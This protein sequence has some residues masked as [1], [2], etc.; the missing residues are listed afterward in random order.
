VT[1]RVRSTSFLVVLPR[2]ES[3]SGLARTSHAVRQPFLFSAGGAERGDARG[4]F[5]ETP[6]KPCRQAGIDIEDA[7]MN[8]NDRIGDWMVPN[9]VCAELWQPVS[10]IRQ[11][12]L[13]NSF[14]Y[15]PINTTPEAV[16][17]WRLISDLDVARYLRCSASAAE[18]EE[19]LVKPLTEALG[20]IGIQLQET[21]LCQ[22]TDSVRAVLI[23]GMD[24]PFW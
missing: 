13:E 7:L 17:A 21:I 15:L 4:C 10:F 12:I 22:P 16:P 19:R 6:G 20:S 5:C 3:A 18:R 14:S 2:Q 24:H 1:T 11:T 9:P 23:T 8:G